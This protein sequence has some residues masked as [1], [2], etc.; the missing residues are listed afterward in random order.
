ML[1]LMI[2]VSMIWIVLCIMV[3]LALML[4]EYYS[5]SIPVFKRNFGYM[6]LGF[7]SVTL[8]Y[9]LYATKDPAQIYNIFIGEYI[10]L[11]ISSYIGPSLSGAEWI[12]FI[13]VSML[14]LLLGSYGIVRYAQLE[15]LESKETMQ[16]RQK[17]DNTGNGVSVFVHGIKNQLISAQVLHKRLEKELA[18]QEPDMEK[19]RLYIADLRE[20]N[21]GMRQRMDELY[22]TVK[23]NALSLQPVSVEEVLKAAMLRFKEKYPEGEVEIGDTFGRIVLADVGSLSEAL[24]NL[25]VNG[26]EAAIQAGN[27]PPRVWIKVKAERLWTVITV[28]DNGGGIPK[29]LQSRIYEPFYTSKNTSS[30]W[31]MGLYCVR[32]IVKSHLGHLRLECVEGRGSTFFIMLPLFDAVQRKG[33]GKNG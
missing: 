24:Y 16:L 11:G 26:Y 1:S 17:L 19:I 21:E 15:Y 7:L 5:T 25:M 27:L 2:R 28:S 8:L 18:L 9:V 29:N 4:Y 31:G 32:R 14:L 30:N 13:F 23:D 33:K 22:R 12:L 3:S 20:L 6:F 10:D